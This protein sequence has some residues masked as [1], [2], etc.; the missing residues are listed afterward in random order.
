M[1]KYRFSWDEQAKDLGA[2][3]RAFEK[4]VCHVCLEDGNAFKDTFKVEKVP[5]IIWIV[6]LV[7]N[8][9]P[10]EV[11]GVFGKLPKAKRLAAKTKKQI[12]GLDR[13]KVT[14]VGTCSN[15]CVE[16]D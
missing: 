15:P 1:P 10:W 16:M 7:M 9:A 14:I 8:G 5:D 3:K 11:I 12:R 2:A 4:G 6:M 13:F